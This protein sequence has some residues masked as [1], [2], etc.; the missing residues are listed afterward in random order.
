M[1]KEL[2]FLSCW[3][4][5]PFFSYFGFINNESIDLV[6]NDNYLGPVSKTTIYTFFCGIL[7]GTGI[8][9]INI[10][11][12]LNSTLT[13][14]HT[15]CTQIGILLYVTFVDYWFFPNPFPTNYYQFN[16]SDSLITSINFI[17][18]LSIVIGYV[19]FLINILKLY[20]QQKLK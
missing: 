1:K 14:F 9:Y 3:I 5:L 10:A 11:K 19:A 13:T 18:L 7:I 15:I 12:K 2:S 4:W 17:S 16:S 20:S 6:I 8:Y